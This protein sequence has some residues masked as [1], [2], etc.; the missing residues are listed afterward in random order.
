MKVMVAQQP[1]LNVTSGCCIEVGC[2]QA[3]SLQAYNCPLQAALPKQQ[4]GRLHAF[5]V[6]AATGRAV[7]LCYIVTI[8]FQ[9]RKSASVLWAVPAG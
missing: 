3:L 5:T 6:A 8:L 2:L 4:T 9:C 7:Q 1:A